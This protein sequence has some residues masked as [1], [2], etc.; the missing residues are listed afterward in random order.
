MERNF[1]TKSLLNAPIAL[2][3][4][5]FP[6]PSRL[7]RALWYWNHISTQ[8]R[9]QSSQ[10]ISMNSFC[11]SHGRI[12]SQGAYWCASIPNRTRCLRVGSLSIFL[13]SNN[14]IRS[15]VWQLFAKILKQVRGKCLKAKAHLSHS[16]EDLRLRQH[17]DLIY[18]ISQKF[19]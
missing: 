10:Y 18:S 6:L 2:S 14:Q 15:L 11:I 16:C 8:N 7:Q 3:S 17:T 12:P 4:L 1:L 13:E 5:Y 9:Q 19:H